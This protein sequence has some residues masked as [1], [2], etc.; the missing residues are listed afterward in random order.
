MNLR[1]M[2][3]ATASLTGVLALS[4]CSADATTDTIDVVGFSVLQTPNEEV[5]EKFEATDAGRDVAFRTAY[6]ASGDMS[7]GVVDGQPADYVQFSLAPDMTRLVDAGMVAEDWDAT[8]TGGIVSSSVVVFV[9][10]PGNPEG[11]DSWDDLVKGDVEVITPN[12]ASSGGARWNIL[13]AWGSVI[14]Q[15]GSEADARRYVAGLLDHTI[16]MPGSAREATSAFVDNGQGDVLLSYENEAILA[17]QAGQDIEY[18]VPPQ[19]L[20]IENPGAVLE[21]ADNAARGF[22]DFVVSEEG[23][24][25]YA[26][27]GFRPV[28]VQLTEFD[29]EGANDPADPFPTP[30]TLLTIDGDFGGWSEASE[31]FFG[32]PDGIIF[33]LMAAAGKSLE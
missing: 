13:A 26:D 24:A 2:T 28:G 16:N 33:E 4:A 27:F 30:E 22:L 17:K 19:T 32:D 6:G 23:Q 15:G 5:F 29:T 1:I 3:A 21:G 31:K 14:S 18:V 7:R 9:V 10:R 20:L 8:P 12:P 11:I 25:I